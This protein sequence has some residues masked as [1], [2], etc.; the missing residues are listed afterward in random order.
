MT[1]N[2][3]QW[4][5]VF[6]PQ[7]PKLSRLLPVLGIALPL[8][9]ASPS[10]SIAQ[11][12]AAGMPPATGRMMPSPL[13][14]ALA[15]AG[16]SLAATVRQ[17]DH[18]RYNRV[19]LEQQDYLADDHDA[20]INVGNAQ[21][22]LMLQQT[23]VPGKNALDLTLRATLAKGSS[24][25]TSLS[26]DVM[27]AKWSTANYVLMPGAAY[28]GN[29]FQSRRIAYSPKLLDPKDIGPDKPTIISD[30]PRL[31][32]GAGPSRIYDR[33]GSMSV[34]SMGY[35][36]PSGQ[37]N[38]WLLTHQ[39]NRLG[40]YGYDIE[41]NR[42]RTQAR[43]SVCS[44]VVR[45]LHKYRITDNRWPSDDRGHDFKE[46]D[47]LT[48]KARIYLQE[49]KILQSLFGQYM[50]LRQDLYPELQ[51]KEGTAGLATTLPMAAAFKVQEHKFNTLNWQPQHGYYAIGKRENFL[52]DWQIGWTGGMIIN[53]PLLYAGADSSV[54]RV[55]RQLDWLFPN[56]ISPSG[57]FYDS[58]EKGTVWLMGDVR[59]PT[60]K[61]WHLVRKGG[62]GLYYVMRH[63]QVMRKRSMPLKD[64]WQQGART[65]AN[66]FV[67]TW[68]KHGQWGQFVDSQ[69]G[70][71]TVGGSASG[72]IVPAALLLA[73]EHFGDTSYLNVAKEA[74]AHY[75]KTA[76]LP[77]LTTGGPGD[78]LQNPDSESAYALI[79]SYMALYEYTGESQYLTWAEMAA[80]Q[81]STWVAAYN[82]K[83]PAQS[84]FGRTGIKSLGAVLANTQNKHGAPG[85]CTF[86]G[87]ALLKLTLATGKPLYA[88]LLRDIAHNMTQYL[89]HPDKPIDKVLDGFMCER[90]SMTDWLEGIG[91][92]TY[93]TT[94]AESSLTLSYTELP[95]LLI[96]P[97]QRRYWAFD[98]VEVQSTT[99]GKS[100][101][102]TLSNPTRSPLKLRM[103][104]QMPKL[105]TGVFNC[106]QDAQYQVLELKPGAS[107]VLKF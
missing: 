89:G 2:L 7:L 46:G 79:E 100:W 9:W 33:S 72:A 20:V 97:A 13:R 1:P 6:A 43:L 84:L 58:G 91:E 12:P 40:D 30:V 32:V 95:G 39:G 37:Y 65:V 25:Q 8:A 88:N 3:W 42:S 34:P 5:V 45:E 107:T 71:V 54:Q 67:R 23:P 31:E 99:K 47:T 57:Y 44:P 24:P 10:A 92:I 53:L 85:I 29:R 106:L 22:R 104:K 36:S 70:D 103:M 82:Y 73:Y 59:K 41:E 21:W 62:D 101:Q 64:H 56:G 28:N 14:T 4:R 83:F 15:Q 18:E 61:Q 11:K 66:A 50:T 35:H 55:V 48:I 19:V 74:A 60:S 90:V 75:Y 77:A 94:W 81:F 51:G 76:T 38:F 105:K 87:Q 68:R 52:M 69:T 102:L 78:A 93:Q 26:L 63:L 98:N 80:E 49:G 16:I 17:H 96:D 86:S 27:V